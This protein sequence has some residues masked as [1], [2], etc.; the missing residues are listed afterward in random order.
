MIRNKKSIVLIPAIVTTI[1][2]GITWF[3]LGIVTNVFLFLVNVFLPPRGKKWLVL[4]SLYFVLNPTKEERAMEEI[5]FFN[6]GMG[7]VYD[8]NALKLAFYLRNKLWPAQV[9]KECMNEVDAMFDEAREAQLT[10]SLI[11][12]VIPQMRY[13]RKGDLA[14]DIKDV[15]RL[16]SQTSAVM[17]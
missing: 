12:H 11:A 4:S 5:K 14:N 7:L 1:I 6:K 13:G 8:F 10:E 17:V 3:I 15:L 16:H 9:L 2:H